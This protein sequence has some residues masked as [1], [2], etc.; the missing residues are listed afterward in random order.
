MKKA[1]CLLCLFILLSCTNNRPTVKIEDHVLTFYYRGHEVL[2][3]FHVDSYNIKLKDKYYIIQCKTVD[4]NDL[5][6]K[7]HEDFTG[8]IEVIEK[9]N[10]QDYHYD[11]R[12]TGNINDNSIDFLQATMNGEKNVKVAYDSEYKESYCRYKGYVDITPIKNKDSFYLNNQFYV[13][14][15]GIKRC[16]IN[17]KFLMILKRL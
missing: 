1:M 13:T 5:K 15:E 16:D 4:D 3:N 9:V 2:T 10:L 12:I 14:E 11:Y 6:I 8:H 7:F 17:K